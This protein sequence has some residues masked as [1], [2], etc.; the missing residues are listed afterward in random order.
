VVAPGGTKEKG[1]MSE[2]HLDQHRVLTDEELERVAGGATAE[3]FWT[4]VIKAIAAVG[5]AIEGTSHSYG[6]GTCNTDGTYTY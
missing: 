5:H 2:T 3:D 1:N 6:T 4:P